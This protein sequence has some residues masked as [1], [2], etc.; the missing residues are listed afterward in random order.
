MS[1]YTENHDRT[2]DEN[3]RA[4]APGLGLPP[5]PSAEQIAS[6]RTPVA[7]KIQ[8][9]GEGGAGGA[10]HRRPRFRWLAAGSAIAA[11]LAVG[12]A[13]F[14]LSAGNAVQASTIIQNL[15]QKQVR[16]MNIR[17]DRVSAEGV[18]VDGL[19]RIRSRN[20][21]R[22]DQLAERDPFGPEEFGALHGAVTFT[23][24]AGFPDLPDASIRFETAFTDRGGWVFVQASDETAD[25]IAEREPRAAF[26]AGMARS[27]VI[28]NIG[29]I[30]PE[31]LK[32]FAP[33]QPPEGALDDLSDDQ[34]DSINQAQDNF[35]KATGVPMDKLVVSHDDEGKRRV[36]VTLGAR[37]NGNGGSPIV[38]VDSADGLLN[39][40][41]GRMLNGTARR[42][43]LE[44]LTGY[45]AK[46]NQDAKV[47]DLGGGKYL[48]VTELSD[49]L[50][51]A[52]PGVKPEREATLTIAYEEQGGVQWA[53]VTNLREATGTIR[54]DF[55][56]DAID[57]SLLEYQRLV[58]PGRTGYLDLNMLKRFFGAE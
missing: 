22:V 51:P 6:W 58:E 45:L 41:A 30:T 31:M 52:A 42:G 34:V 1:E 4:A 18:T 5:A 12:T 15:R 36:T 54:I 8:E 9:A 44:E 28:L 56:D 47:K 26:I 20:P 32:S 25:R 16:G 10:T 40:V 53:E 55:V 24:G 33:P 29:A 2:I 57:A 49:P 43:E 35:G 48:L 19:V 38:R 46:A 39:S 27:G 7:M 11:T 21:I 50:H 37:A 13:L 23:T 17:I 3:L 14:M